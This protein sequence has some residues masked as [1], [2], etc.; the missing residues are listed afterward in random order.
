M[1]DCGFELLQVR[2]GA[3]KSTA[4]QNGRETEIVGTEDAV[5]GEIREILRLSKGVRGEHQRR[6]A[7][8]LGQVI[9]DS[10]KQG[11]SGDLDME[12]LGRTLGLL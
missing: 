10:L 4:Y 6:N 8:L 1:H 7:R 2:T 5:G 12:R 3:A 11:G 9:I